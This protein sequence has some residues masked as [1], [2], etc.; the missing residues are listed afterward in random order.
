MAMVRIIRQTHTWVAVV[1]L[2][3]ISMYIEFVFAVLPALASP[4]ELVPAADSE[5]GWLVGDSKAVCH[6]EADLEL[7]TK[8]LTNR[9]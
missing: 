7:R 5:V 8:R 1:K 9:A 3:L 6:I 4:K 2:F